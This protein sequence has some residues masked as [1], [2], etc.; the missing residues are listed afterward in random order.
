MVFRLEIS[1][2]EITEVPADEARRA[3][4]ACGWSGSMID[5]MFVSKTMLSTVHFYFCRYRDPLDDLIENDL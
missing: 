2:R 3:L 5:Q 4:K 1:T